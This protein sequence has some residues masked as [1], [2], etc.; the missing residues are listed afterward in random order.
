MSKKII[1]VTVGTTIDP[2]RFAKNFETNET[3]VLTDG[4]MGVNVATEVGDYTLPITAAAVNT[5]VGN[6]EVL[7]EK[8]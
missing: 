8:I 7:L 5:I 4:V 3:L 6:I 1:G 2:K